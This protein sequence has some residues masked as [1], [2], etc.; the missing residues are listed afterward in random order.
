VIVVTGAAGF[1][2]S[3][4]VAKLNELGRRDLI[5]VDHFDGDGDPKHANL[6][7][8]KYHAYFDKRA[9]LEDI[10]FN[11]LKENVTCVLHMGACSSTTLQDE[12][13]FKENN[14]Q[15]SCYMAEWA[16]KINARFIYASSA[17][18]YG[19]LTNNY[20]DDEKT[21]RAC[22]PLNL[23]GQS[24]HKFDEWILDRGLQTEVVGLKFFN[25]FGPNEYHKGDMRSVVAKS[26]D[27]AVKEGKIALFKSYSD[28]Y[29]DGE[30]QRDFIY[31][32]DVVDIVLFF[33]EHEHANGIFNVGTGLARTWNDLAKALFAAVGK[34]PDIEYV[35]MPEVLRGKYQYF[36][37]ADMSKLRSIGYDKPFTDLDSAV[38]DYVGYLKQHRYW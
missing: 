3:C 7:G 26:Y 6:T 2:G 28:E 24:K 17:A 13:Y 11:R 34:S 4:I 32:K 35:Q 10:R 14:L 20:R 22:K 16:T 23:Y 21:I 15:Y 33:I 25:V 18:T 38:K 27:R 5:L 30:Q 36:T 12:Q 8:K 19:E 9:F 31:V 37:Q 1:I 29:A